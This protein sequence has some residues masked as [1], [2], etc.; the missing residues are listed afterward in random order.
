MCD[1]FE[2]FFDGR[3]TWGRFSGISPAGGTSSVSPLAGD[4]VEPPSPRGKA[5][6]VD[7]RMTCEGPLPPQA[8]PLP[9]RGRLIM[10]G[11]AAPLKPSPLGRVPG[12]QERS[13][14]VLFPRGGP[15]PSS[16]SWGTADATSGPGRDHRS[17]PALAKNMPPAYFLNASPP[18]GKA[19][20]VLRLLKVF[21]ALS[22]KRID[23]VA[24]CFE[25]IVHVRV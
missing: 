24:D 20:K 18:Y 25:F 4:R 11:F 21:N 22:D 2:K 1:F 23:L 6:K 9:H 14:V 5:Y 10:C 13:L 16:A 12:G 15:L 8:V 19:Y 3:G 7:H 17:L